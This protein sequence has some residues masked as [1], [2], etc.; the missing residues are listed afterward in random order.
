M[1]FHS[2]R[3]SISTFQPDPLATGQPPPCGSDS[4]DCQEDQVKMVEFSHREI[5]KVRKTK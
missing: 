5:A 4:E 3:C 1:R 2:T